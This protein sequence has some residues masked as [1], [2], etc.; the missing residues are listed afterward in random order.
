MA[1]KTTGLH[2]ILSA[3]W[4]Y[5]LLQNALGARKARN[6]LINEHA[7]PGPQVT[8]LDIG[9]GTGEIVPHLPRGVRYHGFD[10]SPAYVEAATRRFGDRATFHCMDIADYQPDASAAPAD[11][12]LAVGILHQ[13][14]DDIAIKLMASARAQLKT[15]GHLI[16]MDGTLIE[17]QSSIARRLILRDRGQNIREPEGYAALARHSFEEVDVTVRHDLLHVP[18]THCVMECRA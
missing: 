14:D 18:Y 12:V 17:G 2:S 3:P 6:R 9:C 10:L 8:V 1:Q 13:L 5:D 16:T 4:A 7:R 15:G 11:L